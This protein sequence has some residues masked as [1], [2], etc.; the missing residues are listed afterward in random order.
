MDRIPLFFTRS[1]MVAGRGFIA[2]VAIEG[3]CILEQTGDDFVSFF[4]VNPGAV[5]GQGQT[6]GEAYH[7][8]LE[9]VRLVLVDFASEASGFEQF[10]EAVE[11]FVLETN[12]PF[13]AAWR[14]AVEDVQAGRVDRSDFPRA[15]DAARPA[16]VVVELV[17]EQRAGRATPTRDL[18]PDLNPQDED[19]PLV[20]VG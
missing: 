1:L 6:R 13:E 16:S 19:L 4:G 8:L 5:A 10:K 12:Y 20:A 9:N 15:L 17:A 11:R 2:R 14:A 18:A 7:D 3:R